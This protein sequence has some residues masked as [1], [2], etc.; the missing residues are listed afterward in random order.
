MKKLSA[1]KA[2]LG[3]R[4][5]IPDPRT[6][7]EVVGCERGWGKRDGEKEKKERGKEREG[8]KRKEKGTE[9]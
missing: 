3:L 6:C 1:K 8:K 5:Q 7:W 9:G 4:L 2:E